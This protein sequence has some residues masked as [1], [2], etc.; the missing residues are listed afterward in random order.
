M[1][2]FEITPEQKKFFPYLLLLLAAIVSSLGLFSSWISI[3]VIGYSGRNSDPGTYT[4]I[5]II[6]FIVVGFSVFVEKIKFYASFLAVLSLILTINILVSYLLWA[7]E[8]Q[9]AVSEFRKSSDSLDD[10]GGLFGNA[11]SGLLDSIKPSLSIGFYLVVASSILG[12]VG[13]ILVIKN[14]NFS[15]P[16]MNDENSL[17]AKNLLSNIGLTRIQMIVC[18][19][20]FVFSLF[21]VI[22][23]SSGMDLDKLT[24]LSSGAATS[25][26]NDSIL[27]TNTKIFE[28]VEVKNTKNQIRVNQPSFDGDPNP[29]DVFAASQFRITNN[30][31]KSIIGISATVDFK[32][33]VGDTIFTG[34]F[35]DDHT[36]A[37]GDS[38]LTSLSRGWTFNQ[39]ED[40]HGLLTGIDA[41][42]TK[43]I[44]SLSKI[45]FNDGTSITE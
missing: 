19:I 2:N 8:F 26:S 29:T 1:D 20:V 32:N 17:K 41:S 45:V 3:G 4:Y 36:V 25:N 5:L 9:Q 14:Q 44:M 10:L 22:S 7:K 30:C 42:K 34:R 40:E 13:N 21:V 18:S 15:R 38:Y 11:L 31:E 27:D 16:Y 28:C 33:V 43:S 24:N 12:L 6:S 23:N 39:F 35:T 37:K